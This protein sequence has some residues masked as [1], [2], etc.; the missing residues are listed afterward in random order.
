MTVEFLGDDEGAPAAEDEDL[1]GSPRHRRAARG[2]ARWRGAFLA[3][4]VATALIIGLIVRVATSG[5]TPRT[6]GRTTPPTVVALPVRPRISAPAGIGNGGWYPL[7]VVAGDDAGGV[8][9]CP[10]FHACAV[11]TDTPA[12]LRF[13][14]RNHLRGVQRIWVKTAVFRYAGTFHNL[15]SRT[16]MVLT[17]GGLV[18]VRVGR[19]SMGGDGYPLKPALDVRALVGGGR[20]DATFH[21]SRPASSADMRRLRAGLQ[22]LAGDSRLTAL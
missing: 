5:S 4:L 13:A 18:I 11:L 3:G 8:A 15:L 20:V 21:P 14:I 17:D 16:V 9:G 2:F 12:P 22:E 6:A 10:P 19:L 1:P 7:P